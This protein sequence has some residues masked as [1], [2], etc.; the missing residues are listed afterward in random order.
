MSFYQLSES[1]AD[2][3]Q[4]FASRH[5]FASILNQSWLHALPSATAFLFVGWANTISELVSRLSRSPSQGVGSRLSPHPPKAARAPWC[6]GRVCVG[7]SPSAT[8]PHLLPKAWG[9]YSSPRSTLWESEEKKVDPPEKRESR[10]VME[11]A[12]VSCWIC[13]ASDWFSSIRLQQASQISSN[14][15]TQTMSGEE[16]RAS[17]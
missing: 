17:L 2:I 6:Q 12:H 7:Q 13:Q 4:G 5:L 11:E 15:S 14:Q 16:G 3:P 1:R 8:A 10:R 9:C